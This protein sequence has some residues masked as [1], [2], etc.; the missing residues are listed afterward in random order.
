MHIYAVLMTLPELVLMGFIIGLTG[1]LAP[2]PTLIATIQSALHVGW[3][4]GPRVT[5]GHILAE[6]GIVLLIATGVSSMPASASP[7]IAWIGGLALMVFGAMTLIGARDA[8]I[9]SDNITDRRSDP[10]IAGLLTSIFNPYFW[11]WWFSV[12]SALLFS[13]LS[14]G[15]VGILAFISGHWLADLSWFTLVSIG[16]HRT[17]TVL[18]TGIYRAILVSCGFILVLFGL[19]FIIQVNM[20]VFVQ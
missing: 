9:A 10:V 19:W 11:I 8:E 13:S 6:L 7:V 5:L 18:S 20:S 3:T 17:R 16:I 2:G 14:Q 4:S 15:P 1:A 12:G